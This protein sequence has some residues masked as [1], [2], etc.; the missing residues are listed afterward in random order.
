M[1]L[2]K[3]C[4]DCKYLFIDL[5]CD[6]YSEYT[7]G[8]AGTWECLKGKFDLSNGDFNGSVVKAAIE[9][10]PD[11]DDF[12]EREDPKPTKPTPNDGYPKGWRIV[13]GDLVE[14]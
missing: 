5:G 10:A 4:L 3:S 6:G 1:A 11:C 12:G 14:E 8:H 9:V 13:G 2:G 7:P